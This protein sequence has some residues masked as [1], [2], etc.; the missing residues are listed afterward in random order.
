[1]ATLHDQGLDRRRVVYAMGSVEAILQRCDAALDAAGHRQPLD[2]DAIHAQVASLA[3]RGLRILAFARNELPPETAALGHPDV[4]TGL[5]FLGLQALIDPPRPEAIAAVRACQS[6][7]VRVKMI[8][9]DHALTA[10]AIASQLGLGGTGTQGSVL[11]EA[12]TG[13]TV[14]QYSDEELVDVAD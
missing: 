5:T 10:V 12:V 13:Q 11:V 14:S 9:G 4:G 7:G 1:M 3:A 6:A 8:T 2:A